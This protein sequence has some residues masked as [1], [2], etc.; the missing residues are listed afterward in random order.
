MP[1]RGVPTSDELNPHRRPHIG[2]RM[3]DQ[4]VLVFALVSTVS[5]LSLILY[6]SYP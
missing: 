1:G 3:P 2:D 4:E 5:I 6:V